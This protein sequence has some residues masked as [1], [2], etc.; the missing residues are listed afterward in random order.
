MLEGC[1]SGRRKVCKGLLLIGAVDVV[2]QCES[3]DNN[4]FIILWHALAHQAGLLP[5]EAGSVAAFHQAH[6]RSSTAFA[7]II[8]GSE[9]TKRFLSGSQSALLGL[10]LAI[11]QHAE[12][13]DTPSTFSTLDRC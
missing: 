7:I 9:A 5:E 10:P 2:S 1:E 13:S 8:E 12:D 4:S 11:N 3:L 6:E